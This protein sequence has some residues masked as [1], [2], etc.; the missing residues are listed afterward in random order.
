[1]TFDESDLRRRA[2]L[3]LILSAVASVGAIAYF[4]YQ[5]DAFTG[6]GLAALFLIAGVWDYRRTMADIDDL[7]E[8]EAERA[9]NEEVR[10]SGPR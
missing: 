3:S 7:A 10:R 1:M 4:G 6:V 8:D 5:G 2:R 9:A